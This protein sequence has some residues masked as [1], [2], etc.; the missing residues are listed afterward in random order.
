MITTRNRSTTRRL[1][2]VLAGASVAVGAYSFGVSSSPGSTR[3]AGFTTSPGGRYAGFS[4]SPGRSQPSR[5]AAPSGR[6][7]GSPQQEYI[8]VGGA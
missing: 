7:A 5:Y 3:G 8:T 6:K 2:A 4:S 1:L